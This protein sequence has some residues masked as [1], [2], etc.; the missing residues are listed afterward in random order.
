M[1][2]RSAHQLREEDLADPDDSSACPLKSGSWSQIPILDVPTGIHSFIL[3]LN[4]L[5][6]PY[7]VFWCEQACSHSCS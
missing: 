3:D 6:M 5:D 7:L 1:L 4:V 2:N